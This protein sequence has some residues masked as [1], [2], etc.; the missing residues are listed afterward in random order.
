[1]DPADWNVTPENRAPS[2]EVTGSHSWGG[3]AEWVRIPA[4]FALRD[5]TNLP[6]EQ[7]AAMP[8]VLMTAVHAVETLG[9]VRA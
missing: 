1:M 9:D 3:N 6:P 7:V 2:F 8:L 5:E 4:R